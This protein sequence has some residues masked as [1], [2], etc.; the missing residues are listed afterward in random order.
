MKP[1]QQRKNSIVVRTQQELELLKQIDSKLDRIESRVDNIQEVATKQG[2]IA[3]AVAGGI[4]GG[5]VTAGIALIK[6][7]L[8]L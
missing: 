6:A 5:L 2:A 1:R 4:T 7:R 3:G 8:G